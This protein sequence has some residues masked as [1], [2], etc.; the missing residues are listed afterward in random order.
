M[1]Q[2]DI[3]R[4]EKINKKKRKL[5]RPALFLV[6]IVIV[7]ISGWLIERKIVHH[8][9]DTM[10]TVQQSNK[11]DINTSTNIK[12]S[13]T[14]LKHFTAE[15][16][17]KLAL[18][19]RYPNTQTFEVPPAITGNNNADERIR[20]IAKSRGYEM[21]SIPISSIVKIN[22]S[23]LEGDD[24]L[25]PLAAKSWERLRSSAKEHNI[26]LSLVSAY[27]SPEFQRNLF[28]NR[29]GIISSDSASIISGSYDSS[30]TSVLTQ[31]AIPGFSRHHNGY[32]IDLGCKDGSKSFLTSSCFEWLSKDN[33]RVAKENGW[34]PSYPE[35]VTNQGPEPEPWEYIWVGDELVRE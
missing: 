12:D 30:I 8:S 13:K 31:A 4:F 11:S 27:R 28:I 10:G 23:G 9:K 35:G 2:V 21:T 32:T 17:N 25:Q 15:E 33:Y 29:L 5:P 1:P 16:F 14:N 3:R 24:L 22:E 19:M 26:P 7:S 20:N 34:I 6:A 18:S